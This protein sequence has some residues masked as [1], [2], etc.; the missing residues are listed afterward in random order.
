MYVYYPSYISRYLFVRDQTVKYKES[1]LVQAR[2]LK[3]LIPINE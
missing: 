1:A 2:Q 3:L